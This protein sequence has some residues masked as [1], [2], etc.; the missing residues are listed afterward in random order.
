[1]STS[2]YRFLMKYSC[3]ELKFIIDDYQVYKYIVNDLKDWERKVFIKKLNYCG[4]SV[5][6]LPKLFYKS[7][8]PRLI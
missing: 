1:M 2:S 4:I 6:K 7:G 5:T 3:E 8:R